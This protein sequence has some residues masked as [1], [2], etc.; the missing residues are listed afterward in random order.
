MVFKRLEDFSVTFKS[1]QFD[2][3]G[4]ETLSVGVGSKIRESFACKK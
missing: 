3:A 2:M 1:A 4:I